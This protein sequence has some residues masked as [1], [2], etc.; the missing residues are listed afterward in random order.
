MG[1]AWPILADEYIRYKTTGRMTDNT[2]PV[3]DLIA[4]LEGIQ[5]EWLPMANM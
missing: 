5:A 1:Q 2:R 4:F 3:A